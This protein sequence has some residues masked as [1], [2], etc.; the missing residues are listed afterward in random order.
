MIQSKKP[1]FQPLRHDAV[2]AQADGLLKQAQA[3]QAEQTAM[4]ETSPLESLYSAAF[5]A[6][7]E[8]KHDQAERIEDML[9]DLISQQTSRL[10]QTQAGQPGLFSRLGTQARKN[11]VQQKRIVQ[12]L[13]DRL[14][15]VREIKDG[16]G[17]H[18]PRIEELAT[19]KLR[20]QEPGLTR[21]WEDMCEARRLYQ[22][23]LRRQE[24][25]KKRALEG[26]RHEH[27]GRGIHREL[28]KFK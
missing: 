11:Q 1:I 10:Q 13:Q 25:D 27:L 24:Q 12:R 4:L 6:L 5:A 3:V 18:G 22:A 9:E 26:E 8:A 16:M 28:Q 7:V 14:E 23:L 21:E 20:A 17:V 19:R 15:V 2:A